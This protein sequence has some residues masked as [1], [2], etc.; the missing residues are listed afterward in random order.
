MTEQIKPSLSYTII[1]DDV[2]Q[3]A[4]GKIS[5]MGLFQNIYAT[6]FPAVHSRIATINEWSD[7][8]GEFTSLTQILSP[9]RR[10]IVRKSTSKIKLK[11][12]HIRHRDISIHLNIEFP[13]SGN[14]WIE[15]FLDDE[16]VKSMPLNVVLVKEQQ[17]H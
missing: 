5:I 7:G 13:I 17:I 4:G 3:E 14:Y 1:C 8:K 12:V 15:I 6:K 2:R 10:K 11:E 16:L 9:D